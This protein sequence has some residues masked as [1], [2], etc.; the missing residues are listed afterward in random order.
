[1]IGEKHDQGKLRYDLIEP[2]FLKG[3]AA[4]LTM[5]AEKYEEDGWKNVPRLEQRYRAALMRH[6]EAMRSGQ[7]VD[8]ESS[9]PHISHVACNAMFLHWVANS[10]LRYEAYETTNVRQHERESYPEDGE[11]RK[12]DSG[13]DDADNDKEVRLLKTS[14]HQIATILD[15]CRTH[16]SLRA[17]LH[18]L[19][20]NWN[21]QIAVSTINKTTYC[22]PD[23]Q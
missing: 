15:H 20:D 14:V 23:E 22:E 13:C 21:Q 9:L 17:C 7:D 6:F 4:V 8:E 3:L 19:R 12:S 10:Q 2:A 1:M 16:E 18:D 11:S 5:G